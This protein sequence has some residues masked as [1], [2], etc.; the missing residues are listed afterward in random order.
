MKL[1]VCIDAL[2]NGR[3]VVE[4][5]RAVKATGI[6]NVEFWFWWDRDLTAIKKAQEE[7]HMNIIAF[8]TPFIS[9]T[10]AAQREEFLKGLKQSLNI[11]AQ[12]NTKYLIA[13]V[14]N[15][16]PGVSRQEQHQ[17]IVQGLKEAV[18]FLEASD[19][20]LLIE[21][22]NIY[23]DH[24]GYYLSSSEEAFQI[25]SE[26][27]SPFVKILFDIYHQQINEGNLLPRITANLDK[28]GHFHGAGNPGRHELLTGEINYLN[29]LKILHSIG[30]E[31]CIGLEYFPLGDPVKGLE[32][33]VLQ[34]K[35]VIR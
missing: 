17:S 12:F 32:E 25:C 35:D 26:I 8:C 5:M 13:Q 20:I 11:A 22:L 31:G 19:A 33:L 23:V 4:S 27:A 18:P 34:L 24:K 30:F 14:G 15:E 9:L 3:D 6:D 16:I 21:P 2:F 10:D 1:S 28:I 29:I 7:L